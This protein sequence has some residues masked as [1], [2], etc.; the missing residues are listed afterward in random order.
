MGSRSGCDYTHQNKAGCDLSPYAKPPEAFQYFPDKPEFGSKKSDVAYCPMR[1]QHLI[2]CSSDKV[3]STLIGE[4]F[5]E[6][7]RCYETDAGIP[8]CLETYCNPVEKTLSFFV[9]GK[10]FHCTYHGQVIDVNSGYS[11]V[12]PRIAAVCPDLVCPANCSGKG[13]CDY[14]KEVPQCNCDN[15]IDDTEGCFL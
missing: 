3:T 10:Y 2:S 13:T 7:S 14:C 9:Q 12:C 1:S 8:V 5:E 4:S 15:P 6:N 11:V